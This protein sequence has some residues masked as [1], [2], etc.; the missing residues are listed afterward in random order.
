MTLTAER[1]RALLSYDARTGV[2][3]RIVR[4]SN[5]CRVGDTAG[6]LTFYGYLSVCVDGKDHFAHRLAWLYMTGEWP[7]GNIDHIDGDKTNNRWSNLRDV[8]QAVNMQNLRA[9]HKDSTTGLL[10]VSYCKERRR[11]Y[12]RIYA[13]GHRASLGGFSSAEDA[14]AAYQAAK[15]RHHSEA[16]Q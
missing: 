14:S 12:A 9:A 1:L 2:L 6:S 16:M 10:G 11:W 15:K 7:R 13:R 4:T 5:R 3:T 8:D